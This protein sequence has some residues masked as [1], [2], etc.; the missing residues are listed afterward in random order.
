MG[1]FTLELKAKYV[2][3]LL[4]DRECAEA[5]AI[6]EREAGDY[7]FL[8]YLQQPLLDGLKSG[9]FAAHSPGERFDALFEYQERTGRSELLGPLRDACAQTFAEQVSTHGDYN[10]AVRFVDYLADKPKFLAVFDPKHIDKLVEGLIDWR[11]G[12]TYKVGI[13]KGSLSAAPA[14]S[15]AFTAS[16]KKRNAVA[17]SATDTGIGHAMV[18]WNRDDEGVWVGSPAMGDSYDPVTVAPEKYLQQE[19]YHVRGQGIAFVFEGLARLADP[20]YSNCSSEV[21][22]VL[23]D[24]CKDF[25]SGGGARLIRENYRNMILT[26]TRYKP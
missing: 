12:D 5:V 24:L 8:N 15:S 2:G 9:L 23:E 6:I 1:A 7:R 18:I 22:P 14:L 16:L 13:V 11:D 17:Y 19:D 26:A 25:F 21:Q 10:W 20:K 3:R 4:E